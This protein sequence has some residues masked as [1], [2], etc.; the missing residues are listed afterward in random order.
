MEWK[1]GGREGGNASITFVV[2]FVV[3]S[4]SI[5][6]MGMEGASERRRKLLRGGSNGGG[7]ETLLSLSLSLSIPVRLTQ[8]FSPL[9][10]FSYDFPLLFSLTARFLC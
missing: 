4:F 9:N 8:K 3:G 10:S 5:S 7:M 2:S 6:Y 1:R